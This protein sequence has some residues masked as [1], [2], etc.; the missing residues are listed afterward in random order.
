MNCNATHNA[1]SSPVSVSGAMRFDLPTGLTTVQSGQAVARVNLSARQAKALGLLT[2][3]TYGP[4]SIGSLNSAAL[5]SSLE[6]KLR[7]TTASLG[8]TLYKLT[9]KDRVT[10][11]GQPICALRASARRTSDNACTGWPTTTATDAVRGVKDARPWDT[12]KPLGQIVALAGWPTARSADGEKNVRTLEG[13]LSEIA[14]KGSPQDMAQAAAISG[15]AR[16]TDT[17]ELL[18]G[19]PAGMES[20]GQ[21][22]PAHSRWLMGLPVEW[23]VCA[24]MAMPSFRKSR[25]PSLKPISCAT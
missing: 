2:S 3:G 10:P 6:N 12:G 19:L 21:L 8:S 4:R 24:P 1:I 5:Q 16:L 13:S 15:P 14:R 17:G 18:T 20:G 7:A 9:W 25:K 11:Q 22:N 23:D